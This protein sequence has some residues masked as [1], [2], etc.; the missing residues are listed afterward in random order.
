MKIAVSSQGGSLNAQ[1]AKNF[2]RCPYFLIVDS[3]TMKFEPVYN[4]ASSMTGGAGPAAARVI[5]EKGSK[6]VLTGQVGPNAMSAL[7]GYGIE[8]VTV[9]SDTVREAVEGYLK[10]KKTED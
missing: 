8:A 6:I 4:P 3:E 10:N 9:S 7:A 5:N 2:G 1:V